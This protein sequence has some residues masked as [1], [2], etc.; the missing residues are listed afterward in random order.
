MTDGQGHIESHDA[1]VRAALENYFGCLDRGEPVDREQFLSSHPEIAGELRS[2][3]ATAEQ[4]ERMAASQRGSRRSR[5][6]A[7]PEKSTHSVIR[8]DMETAIPRGVREAG[9]RM[10]NSEGLPQ[11]FGRYHVL[12]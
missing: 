6:K 11:H 10:S 2:F 3:L 8:R 4:S 9:D 12:K 1:R 7:A 5:A